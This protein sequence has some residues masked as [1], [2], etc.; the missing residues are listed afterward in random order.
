MANEKSKQKYTVLCW[1]ACGGPDEAQ[2]RIAELVAVGESPEAARKFVLCGIDY[3]P[4]R[5]AV[6]GDVV[7]DIPLMSLQWLVEGGHIAPMPRGDA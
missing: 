2:R 7:D 3:P 6:E 1:G 4:G 5:R